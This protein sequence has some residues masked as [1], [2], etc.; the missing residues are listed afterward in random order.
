[1][2]VFDRTFRA[3]VMLPCVRVT[4]TIRKATTMGS[5]VFWAGVAAALTLVVVFLGNK[6]M[7]K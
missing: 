5:S 2:A 1:M 6:G 4:I 7:A 3:P